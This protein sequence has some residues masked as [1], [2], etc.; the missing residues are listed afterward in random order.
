MSRPTCCL[1]VEPARAEPRSGRM[2]AAFPAT[3]AGCARVVTSARAR[4]HRRGP[5]RRTRPN[6]PCAYL[7]EL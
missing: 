5:A 3:I 1:T 4:R 2:P 7:K 6:G